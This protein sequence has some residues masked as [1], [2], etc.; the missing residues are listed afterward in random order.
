MTAVTKLPGAGRRGVPLP[1]TAAGPFRPPR[2][3]TALSL[4]VA[5][6]GVAQA[7]KV[8]A[9]WP[10]KM[11]QRSARSVPAFSAFRDVAQV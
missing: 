7:E 6:Q 9:Q 1:L 4:F 3:R 10:T 8:G 2:P 11:P 5:A